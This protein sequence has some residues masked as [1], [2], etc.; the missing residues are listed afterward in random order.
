MVRDWRI[1]YSD[2]G[3]IL[4]VINKIWPR[5]DSREYYTVRSFLIFTAYQIIIWVIKRRR[6]RQWNMWKT[7]DEKKCIQVFFWKT[8]L[9]EMSMCGRKDNHKLDLVYDVR[10]WSRF[11]CPRIGSSGWLSWPRSQKTVF[12]LKRGGFVCYLRI[13]KLI[14]KD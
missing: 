12:L 14:R 11:I 1:L 2:D 4:L 9:N 3:A 10:V 6:T 13:C 7:W 5:W 8:W